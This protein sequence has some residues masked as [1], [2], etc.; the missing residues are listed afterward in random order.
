MGARWQESTRTYKCALCNYG[1][2]QAQ[3]LCNECRIES[4]AVSDTGKFDRG[5][6]TIL[7]D[8]LHW[9]DVPERIKYKLGVQCT[10]GHLGTSQITSY[11]PLMLLIAVVVYVLQT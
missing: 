7:H 4:Y 5:L 11:Q 2:F 6:K 3:Y 9:L 8:E 10:D 1:M